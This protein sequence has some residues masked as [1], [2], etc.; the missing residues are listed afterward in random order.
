MTSSSIKV[1]TLDF[2]MVSLES[3]EGC[4]IYELFLAT[5][6]TIFTSTK[7]RLDIG[8]LKNYINYY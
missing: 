6:V 1:G 8:K 7:S 4:A 2:E 5:C 3:A